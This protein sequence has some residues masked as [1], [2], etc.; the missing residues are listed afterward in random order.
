MSR[1]TLKSSAF[2]AMQMTLMVLTAV[3]SGA[4][5]LTAPPAPP[6]GSTANSLVIAGNVAID[7]LTLNVN[8]FPGNGVGITIN[9]GTA[10]LTNT[11]INLGSSGGVNGIV[12]NGPG[13]TLTLG[14]GSSV[15]ASGG[16]GR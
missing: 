11:A 4:Q 5:L 10:T 15:N 9:S 16:G 8:F 12:A 13:V 2:L 1:M 3:R 6:P 14:A 7:H